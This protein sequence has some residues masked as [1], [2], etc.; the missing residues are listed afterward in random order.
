MATLSL[1]T[2][3]CEI[4]VQAQE[5]RFSQ[6]QTIPLLVN[7][8]FAGTQS[9]YALHLNYRVQSVGLLAYKTGYFSF[10]MPLYDKAQEPRHVGGLSVG[11]INDMAGEAGEIKTNG[12]N[13]S[14]AYSILFDRFGVQSL[15]FG[16]QG[17]YMLT[18][19]DFGTLN[20]PSQVTYY[21]FDPGRQPTDVLEGRNSFVRFNAGLI[22]SYNPANNQLKNDQGPRFF[23]GFATSNLNS[24][25]QSFLQND[26]YSLPLLYKLH[27]GSQIQLN[28][29]VSLA[30]DFI[31]MTQNELYQ[32]TLGTL[33]NYE[34]EVKVTNN[35]SLTKLN[36]FAGSWYRSTDALVLLVGASNRRFNAAFSY[37]VNTVPAKAGIDGQGAVELSLSL[38][39]LKEKELRKISSPLF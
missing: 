12:L 39:F 13:I 21:G 6:Y 17:E 26:S 5:V 3:F 16:L 38:K 37:D 7:P 4:N 31:V 15:T 20:W 33:L 10:T 11:A 30:P 24:P 1:C 9:D 18:S 14:G 23:L 32:F 35:P 22:W 25:Q 27:G 29:R 19:I 28:Q 36:F 8:A 34:K 2:L